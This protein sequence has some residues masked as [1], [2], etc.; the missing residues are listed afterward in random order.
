[1][2]DSDDMIICVFSGAYD[3]LYSILLI[4]RQ[5]LMTDIRNSYRCM[6]D[7]VEEAKKLWQRIKD[8]IPVDYK[9]GWHPLGLN[10][11]YIIFK[12]YIIGM[13]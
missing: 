4:S 5:V 7:S 10:E 6:W 11:R 12:T 1:M 2:L 3:L 9:P 8:Y 13:R